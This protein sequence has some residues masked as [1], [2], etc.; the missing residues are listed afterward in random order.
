M[1]PWTLNTSRQTH[2]LFSILRDRINFH[3]SS[4]FIEEILTHLFQYMKGFSSNNYRK[5][6]QEQH[7]ENKGYIIIRK[8]FIFLCAVKCSEVLQVT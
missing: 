5:I 3:Q 8:P 6:H 7:I 2:S 4:F 1:H